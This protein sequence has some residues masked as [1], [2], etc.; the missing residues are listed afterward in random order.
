M[1]DLVPIISEE[2]K[3]YGYITGVEV[4]RP[5]KRKVR[6]KNNIQWY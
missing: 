5:V 2:E 1:S 3:F 4:E 6:P